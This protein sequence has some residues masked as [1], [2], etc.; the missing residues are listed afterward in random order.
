MFWQKS[1]IAL[2]KILENKPFQIHMNPEGLFNEQL[3]IP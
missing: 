1:S 3:N 2:Q